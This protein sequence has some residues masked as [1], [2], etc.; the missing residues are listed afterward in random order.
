MLHRNIDK[1]VADVRPLLTSSIPIFVFGEV[2]GQTQLAPSL[3]LVKPRA[4]RLFDRFHRVA[5]QRKPE[6]RPLHRGDLEDDLRRAR[7]ITGLTAVI[8]ALD[9]GR[10]ADDL[11]IFGPSCTWR[12]DAAPTEEN[13]MMWPARCWRIMGIAAFVTMIVP[14]RFVSICLR[15]SESSVSSMEFTLRNRRCLRQ[16]RDHRSC[17]WRF[18]RRPPLRWGRRH[19]AQ[20]F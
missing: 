16:H 20:P 4:I 8:R 13:W 12:S 15:K 18:R 1:A 19:R 14:N 17:R 3:K 2:S 6:R 7:R 10:C 11:V 5:S 9:P